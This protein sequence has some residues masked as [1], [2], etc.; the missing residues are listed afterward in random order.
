M[1]VCLERDADLHMVQLMPLTVSVLPAHL[2]SPE[3]GRQ[4]GVH[5][6]CWLMR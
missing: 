5:F 4:M 1:V 2:G 3:K 6:V